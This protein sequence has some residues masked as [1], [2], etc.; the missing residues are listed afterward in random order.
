MKLH[1][2]KYDALASLRA[3]V[4]GNLEKYR[5]PTNDWIYDFF[6]DEEPF[7]EFMTTVGDISLV[8]T[9]KEQGKADVQNVIT[10]YSAMMNITDT[11]ASDER[12][13]AGMC[14][15][16]MWEFVNKRWEASASKKITK[17]DVLSRYFYGQGRRRSLITNTLAKLWWVGRLTYDPDRKDPFELTH[18][19]EDDFSRK[20]LI[21]F[22]SNY[23]SSRPVALGLL[24]ALTDLERNTACTGKERKLIYQE[25]SKYLNILGGTM[26]LDY[27]TRE[28][29]ETRVKNHILSMKKSEMTV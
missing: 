13:W 29:I 5:L 11:Q 22:S 28:E 24:S 7:G 17:E 4:E 10:L 26:I 8:C 20:T 19:F 14:H 12:L 23:M 18:Y 15:G 2:L 9:E 21:L 25:A 1:F 27:F 3:N 6:G 16:D